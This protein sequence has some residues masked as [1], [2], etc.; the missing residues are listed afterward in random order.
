MAR[1]TKCPIAAQT[2]RVSQIEI[3]ACTYTNTHTHTHKHEIS[4]NVFE[5]LGNVTFNVYKQL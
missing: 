3:R 1:G 4:D 5:T 2:I